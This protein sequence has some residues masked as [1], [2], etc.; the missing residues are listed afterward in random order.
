MD[1]LL[2]ALLTHLI[3]SSNPDYVEIMSNYECFRSIINANIDASAK[4]F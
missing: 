4:A 1:N 3:D 2:T